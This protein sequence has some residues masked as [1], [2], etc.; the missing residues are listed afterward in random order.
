MD[1]AVRDMT[2][3]AADAQA[4]ATRSVSASRE[5]AS[6]VKDVAVGAEQL[7]DSISSITHAVER[8]RTSIGEAAARA[9]T[10]SQRIDSLSKNAQSVSDVA[11]FIDAIARQTNLLALNA[12]IEASRAGAA[13]RGFAVVASEVKL[14]AGQTA[15]ATDDISERI[16]EVR[17]RTTE[18]VETIRTI[19]ATNSA[20][21]SHADTIANTVVDQNSVAAAILNNIR[22]TA[23]WATDLSRVVEELTVAVDR[24]KLAA[25]QVQIASDSSAAVEEKFSRL[26]DQ[27]LEKVRAA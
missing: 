18:A 24:A 1:R 10:A 17:Q 22:D 6:N 23:G 16:E 14:L 19:S 13:G 20:A 27:F 15:K 12:T 25:N 11:S 7:S 5:L 2:A 26:I 9:E 4:G 21:A 3:A 8:A